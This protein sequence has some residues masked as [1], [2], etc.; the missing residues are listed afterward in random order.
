MSILNFE[1]KVVSKSYLTI[2][3]L[4]NNYKLDIKYTT[5]NCIELQKNNFGFELILP[6]RYKNKDN[7]EVINHAIQKLYTEVAKREL[8]ISM[9][10]VRHIV[11]FAPED[12]QIKRIKNSFCKSTRDKVLVINPDIIQ[13]SRE[14]INTT[15]IQEFCKMKFKSGSKAYKEAIKTAIQRYEGYKSNSNLKNVGNFL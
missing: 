3:V 2:S 10:L 14:I 6:K 5:A 1:K 9:E 15:L 7:V 11:K 12:Y 8:E 13:Y 4:G